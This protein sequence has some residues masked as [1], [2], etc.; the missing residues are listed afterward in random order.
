MRAWS[1][2]AAIALVAAALGAGCSGAQGEARTAADETGET[3]DSA[4][5]RG[6]TEASEDVAYVDLPACQA[7]DDNDMDPL[8]RWI[9]VYPIASGGAVMV[10]TGPTAEQMDVEA[11]LEMAAVEGYEDVT[12]GTAVVV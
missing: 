7:L 10:F 1:R 6:A 11:A 12:C 8:Q 9:G 3:S 2:E 4:A 5:A